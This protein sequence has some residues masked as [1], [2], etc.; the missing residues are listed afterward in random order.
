M[1]AIRVLRNVLLAGVCAMATACGGEDGTP[2]DEASVDKDAPP[3]T[4][5]PEPGSPAVSV[6]G[7]ERLGWDQQDLN[8]SRLSAYTFT[9]YVDGR[10][11]R[12]SDVQCSA[13]AIGATCSAR[14]PAMSAGTHTLELTTALDGRESGRSFSIVVRVGSGLLVPDGALVPSSNGVGADA[15]VAC[16]EAKGCVGIRPLVQSREILGAPVALPDGRI[17]FVEGEARVRVLTP[18]GVLEEPAFVVSRPGV[19][20]VDLAV[21]PRYLE[22]RTLYLLIVETEGGRSAVSVSRV[23][24]VG[25]RLGEEAVVVPGISVASDMGPRLAVDRLS[26]IYL[27]LPS[28]GRGGTGSVLRFTADGRVPWDT[29]QSSPSFGSGPAHPRALAFDGSE[30]TLWVAGASAT[31]PGTLTAFSLAPPT[32]G[33]AVQVRAVSTGD[34]DVDVAALSKFGEA[35]DGDGFLFVDESGGLWSGWP[36][37]SRDAVLLRPVDAWI[38]T[39]LRVSAAPVGALVV[40]RVDREQAGLPAY[41][42][43]L[44][45]RTASTA[46]R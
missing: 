2:P 3:P 10:G 7:N 4:S 11:S 1:T 36:G 46:A 5:S 34:A 23:R 41:A 19:R 17:L 27:A 39:A 44:V 15:P 22:N 18:Q 33:A 9:I 12:A 25:N 35:A 40:A 20:V 31:G 30:N 21:D 45:T 24:D 37:Q 13:R 38:G 42:I 32:P 26:R 28:E 16:T 6:R 29:G 14:L 43:H 8:L